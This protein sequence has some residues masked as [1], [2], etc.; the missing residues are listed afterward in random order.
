MPHWKRGVLRRDPALTTNG[1]SRLAD[2]VVKLL[3]RFAARR[4]RATIHLDDFDELAA[5]LAPLIHH[6]LIEAKI[7]GLRI[8][9]ADRERE[10][11]K[12][13]MQLAR[14]DEFGAPGTPKEL[15]EAGG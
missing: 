15:S 9:P 10:K 5:A 4:G 2:A 13:V 8:V 1:E 11:R 14:T 3:R 6:G 12:L 7:E